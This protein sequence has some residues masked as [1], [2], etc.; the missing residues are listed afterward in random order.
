MTES[1][2]K[3]SYRG[4]EPGRTQLQQKQPMKDTQGK[5]LHF[6]LIHSVLWIFI[7]HNYKNHG[8]HNHGKTVTP[9]GEI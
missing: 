1:F 3:W 2:Q 5:T 4:K 8:A 6:F 7:I 9:D